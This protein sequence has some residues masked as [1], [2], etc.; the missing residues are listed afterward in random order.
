MLMRHARRRHARGLLN[1]CSESSHSDVTPHLAFCFR[2]IVICGALEAI[3][4][5]AAG[6]SNDLSELP[7]PRGESP[8]PKEMR[9]ICSNSSRQF[10]LTKAIRTDN[11]MPFASPNS[12]F[13]LSKLSVWWVKLGIEI[14]RIKPGHP[15]QNGRHER[16]HLTLELETTKPAGKNFLQQQ[17]K[18]DDFVRTRRSMLLDEARSISV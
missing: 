14:E 7:A 18:F 16:M 1:W 17:A 5:C 12:L 11:G 4:H 15:Q 8:A 13:D 10:G 3:Q 6:A 2:G 9:S